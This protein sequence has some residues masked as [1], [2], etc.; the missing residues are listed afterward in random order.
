MHETKTVDT[1][2]RLWV[3]LQPHPD[4]PSALLQSAVKVIADS[5]KVSYDSSKT[6][7]IHYCDTILAI[8]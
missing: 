7:N 3:S 4:I 6:I 1:D 2:F 8:P 5:P